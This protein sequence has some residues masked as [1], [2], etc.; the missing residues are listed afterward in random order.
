MSAVTNDINGTGVP[1]VPPEAHQSAESEPLM[2]GLLEEARAYLALANNGYTF[3]NCMPQ[4]LRR[5]ADELVARREIESATILDFA[6]NLVRVYFTK[7]AA[8]I[9][10]RRDGALDA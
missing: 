8:A 3:A 4:R 7:K 9:Y 10:L 1:P 2:E 5:A 6:K